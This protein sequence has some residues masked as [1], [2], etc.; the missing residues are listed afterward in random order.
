[1]P[2]YY[3]QNGEDAILWSLFINR[4]EPGYFV[5]V[6][7]LDGTR[8]SN[9]Y[10]FE[11]EGWNGVCIEAHNDYIDLLRKARPGSICVHAAVSDCNESEVKFYANKRGSLST[12]DP[13]QEDYFRRQYGE[14]FTGFE[15]QKVQMR[16]LDSILEEVKAPSPIDV[17][18]IDVEGY[19]VEVLKGF[20]LSKYRPRVLVIE[21][22]YDEEKVKMDAYMIGAGYIKTRELGSNIFYCRDR[23]DVQTI[24]HASNDISLMHTKHPL[25]SESNSDTI[26]SRQVVKHWLGYRIAQKIRRIPFLIYKSNKRT[27]SPLFEKG[28]HGDKFLIQLVDSLMPQIYSFIETGSNVGTTALYI[29]KTYPDIM[30]YSCEVDEL[31]F[32]ELQRNLSGFANAEVYCQKSPEFLYLL[33]DTHKHN[34]DRRNLFWLDAHGY[35]FRWPLRDE[36][37]FI[38]ENFQSAV[39][40][41]DDFEVPGKPEFNFMKN[42]DQLCNFRYIKNALA[43]EKQ[44]WVIYPNYT[45]HTSPHHP[46]VGYVVIIFGMDELPLAEEIQQYFSISKYIH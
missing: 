15:V 20:D 14:F 36:V 27:L 22:I 32:Q 8:F 16:K 18:S 17:I 13:S 37:A 11:L 12:L 23:T 7:A 19:E 29:A 39:L 46:L 28:F 21:A 3:S 5:D 44:Y 42:G 4:K 2:I 34:R 25:D 26:E 24:A 40:I 9:T 1:M 38:T 43:K 6:G 45:E 31:A 33:N 30:I 10:S 35:G 41:I